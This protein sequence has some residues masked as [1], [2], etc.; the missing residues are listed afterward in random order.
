MVY[1]VRHARRKALAWR[2][3]QKGATPSLVTPKLYDVFD[4]ELNIEDA[5]RIE[6]SFAF[7]YNYPE[8]SQ[9]GGRFA[10]LSFGA[11]LRGASAA[12][13]IP[14]EGVFLRA[15]GF[16]EAAVGSTPDITFTYALG[17]PHA[18]TGTPA[19]DMDPIYSA[20]MFRDQLRDN[21]DD[22]VG[23]CV[24]N[25]TAGMKPFYR[26]ALR[27]Q[28]TD[29]TSTTANSTEGNLTESREAGSAAI[30]VQNESLTVGGAAVVLRM[31]EFDQ[32]NVVDTRPSFNGRQ[33]Y[34]ICEITDLMPKMTLEIEA[35]DLD[36]IDFGDLFITRSTVAVAF[37]HNSGG[38][39]RQVCAVSFT[40]YIDSPPEY[41]EDNG[42]IMM[43]L[44]LSQSPS[45]GPFTMAWS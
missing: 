11:F 14:P 41:F 15:C 10:L 7:G 13:E 12:D 32:G 37:T 9:I 45:T 31:L 5:D 44:V 42:K 39:A 19:G 33:G 18:Y 26:F 27:G 30:P 2:K 20:M 36:L 3:Y 25:F 8:K 1:Y 43:K 40:G 28:L 4:L 24:I 16:A 35:P 6:Q 21:L 23:N 34:E 38:A 22:L 17:D 29:A